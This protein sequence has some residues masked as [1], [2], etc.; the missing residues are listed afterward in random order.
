MRG[1]EIVQFAAALNGAFNEEEVTT[2]LLRLNRKF[3]DYVTAKLTFPKQLEQLVAT[4]NSQAWVAQLV[5]QAI[6]ERSSNAAIKDFLAAYPGWDPTKAQ[7]LAHPSDALRVFG[8]KSFI[9]R[10]DLR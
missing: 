6:E 7:L 5:L 1:S 9:G 10:A 8:G 3:T 4:A 2:L